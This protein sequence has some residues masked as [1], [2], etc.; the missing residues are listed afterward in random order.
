MWWTKAARTDKGVH[1][2]ANV[3][4][5][6][7]QL[8]N[9]EALEAVVAQLNAELPPAIRV[10]G[11]RRVTKSFDAHKLCDSRLYDYLIPVRVLRAAAAAAVAAEPAGGAAV[12][13]GAAL[14]EDE[15]TRINALLRAFVGT[16]AFHNYTS[17][18]PPGSPQ[19]K[20]HIL[21]VRLA[22]APVLR[23]ERYVALRFHGASF[24]LHHIRKVCAGLRAA[25]A[26]AWGYPAMRCRFTTLSEGTTRARAEPRGPSRGERGARLSARPSDRRR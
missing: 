12:D 26:E 9:G 21:D 14:S 7:C 18:L 25:T 23:G 3:I 13:W 10:L 11:M 1:A 8:E 20:R 24:L 2:L 5:F 17:G 19:A 15:S 6:Q 4:S 22:P 16:H